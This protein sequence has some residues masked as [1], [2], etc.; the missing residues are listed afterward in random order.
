MAD[1]ET[2]FVVDADELLNAMGNISGASKDASQD[3]TKLGADTD[4]ATKTGTKGFGGLAAGAKVAAGAIAAVAAAVAG[5]VKLTLDLSATSNIYAK[6]ARQLGT[7]AEEL[8][9]IEGAFN[10]LTT[11]NVDAVQSLTKLQRSLAEAQ[12][13]TKS[14]TDA[15]AALGIR[16]EEA[17]KA[18]AG[19]SVTDQLT[20][21]ADGMANVEGTAKKTQ[22]SMDLLG[23]SGAALVPAFED[24]GAAI[25]EA[26]RQIEEA[27]VISDETAANAEKLEDSMYLLKQSTTVLKAEGLGP[28]IPTLTQISNATKTMMAGFRNS[29]GAKKMGETINRV[30]REWIVPAVAMAGNVAEDFID[31]MMAVPDVARSLS[32]AIT[33]PFKALLSNMKAIREGLTGDLSLSQVAGIIQDN[34]SKISTSLGSVADPLLELNE[35]LIGNSLRWQALTETFL[36]AST[37]AVDLGDN[38]QDLGDDIKEVGEKAAVA[39]PKVKDFFKAAMSHLGANSEAMKEWGAAAVRQLDAVDAAVARSADTFRARF[40]ATTE[41]L[42]SFGS[43]FGTLSD[44][45]IANS[46]RMTK[47]Q[48]AASLAL[49]YAEKAVATARA[50][51]LAV[52]AAVEAGAA[53][54]T[55]GPGAVAAAAGA[56]G[57]IMAALAVG[58]SAAAPPKFHSGTD[59]AAPAMGS[60]EFT[61]TLEEGEAIVSRQGMAQE[62]ARETVSA[63]NRGQSVGGDRVIA[64]TKVNNTTTFAAEYE[65]IKTGR[66]PYSGKIEQAQPYR[67]G[68]RVLKGT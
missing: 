33:A 59:Y 31:T 44:V 48:K 39:T 20:T 38:T 63:L 68:L 9:K 24:G 36:S 45:I 10:L 41:I 52:V 66:S 49:F 40:A 30:F 53:A 15:F 47:E 34:A 21:V 3:V 42:S 62:G 67:M 12:D 27:G 32:D 46:K 1:I 4:K 13:G 16:G 11:G 5:A 25:V 18:F 64:I 51:V 58:I 2:R 6:N 55:G 50:V 8:Q 7:T 65:A 54:A 17:I 61:A 14:Y 29:G 35:E 23:R 57:A 22:I 60:R 28:L 56:V 26:M 19:M 43:F 37:E